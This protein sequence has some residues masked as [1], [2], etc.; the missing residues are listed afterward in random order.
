MIAEAANTP[1]IAEMP[2]E[3]SNTNLFG[4]VLEFCRLLKSAGLAK[5]RTFAV[6]AHTGF[7]D[8]GCMR[9]AWT[10]R[11]FGSKSI[12]CRNVFGVAVVPPPPAVEGRR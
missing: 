8:E 2:G 1:V 6:H 4:R 9:T 12:A 11:L 5:I 3:G 10:K 7:K